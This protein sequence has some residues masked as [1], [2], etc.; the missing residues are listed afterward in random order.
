MST[1]TD[2]HNRV[3]ENVTVDYNDRVTPQLVRLFNEKNE[4]WGTLKG[5]VSADNINIDGGLITGVT[6][7]DSVLTGNITLPGGYDLGRIGDSIRQISVDLDA[8]SA[9]L[10]REEDTR[11]T[12]DNALGYRI[13]T[14]NTRIDNF[15]DDVA[16]E[17]GI[18]SV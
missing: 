16:R 8:T 9:R 2:L 11:L 13:D 15:Q 4:F 6:L 17:F 1:Y 5:H 12:A 14:I 10:F 18:L 7:K 3:K